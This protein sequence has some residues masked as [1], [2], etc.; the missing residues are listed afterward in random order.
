MRQFST[1][2][3]LL[4]ILTV[5][6]LVSGYLHHRVRQPIT[7]TVNAWVDPPLYPEVEP[8][9]RH[10]EDLL[11]EAEALFA[12]DKP[13]QA[14][15][16]YQ[17]A[18]R[19]LEEQPSEMLEARAL[20]GLGDVSGL[21][22]DL[23]RGL[24]LHQ[25]ARTLFRRLGLTAA[26]AQSLQNLGLAYTSL[27]EVDLAKDHFELA[28]D[29]YRA[30]WRRAIVLM[31]LATQHDLEGDH[32]LAVQQLRQAFVLLS[33]S[34][35]ATVEERSLIKS[36]LL[37]RLAGASMRQGSLDVAELAF[38]SSLAILDTWGYPRDRAVARSNFGVLRMAQG[39]PDLARD[40]ILAGLD[41][42][43]ESS[44]DRERALLHFRL[45]QAY[46]K[47]EDFEAAQE[48]LVGSL[49]YIESALQ[50]T[51]TSVLR[52][53]FTA[54]HHVIREELIALLLERQRLEKDPQ[55]G[56]MALLTAERGRSTDLL[57]RLRTDNRSA[58]SD[59]QGK[60]SSPLRS[61]ERQIRN[62]EHQRLQAIA[63]GQG[64]DAIADAEAQQR[65]LIFKRQAMTEAEHSSHDRNPEESAEPFDLAQV[66]RLLDPDTLLLYYS[67]G[68]QSSALWQIDSAG[69]QTHELPHQATLDPWVHTV[70]D[71]L[72]ISDQELA[73][74]LL[75]E[76]RQAVETLSATL[77]D[78]VAEALQGQRLVILTDGPLQ[79]LPFAVLEHPIHGRRL[80]ADHDIVYV[81]S[82]SA[83]EALR[84][85]ELQ[86]PTRSALGVTV[87]ADPRYASSSV[88]AHPSHS[89]TPPPLTHSAS[90][91]E[92]IGDLLPPTAGGH[93]FLG[94]E[95]RRGLLI[96]NIL[97]PSDILHFSVHGELDTARP[98]LSHLIFALW[99]DE[100]KPLDGRLYVHEIDGIDLSCDLLVLSACNTARGKILRGEGLVGMP[101]AAL[102]A[103]AQR[104][105]VS[106]WFV[107]DEATAEL[108]KHFYSALLAEGLA[109]PAALAQ[110]KRRLMTQ[111][112]P[113]WQ[114]PYYWAGFVL[115]GDWRW[116]HS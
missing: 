46:R 42:L 61:I 79:L 38:R 55:F 90:E 23:Y 95:A 103:G 91:A 37:D 87:V 106:L 60:P 21:F 44:F 15:P 29:R 110:A 71:W 116:P 83:L 109:P 48:L 16:V 113:E 53:A 62:L 3:R 1:L 14:F 114:R 40:E 111:G 32:G 96:D 41:M 47:L 27:G 86:R 81:P 75:R 8:E 43:P 58:H 69:I 99:D 78:P 59:G 22:G 45:A 85:R 28:F 65:Q 50:A 26:E 98:E 54:R 12:N 56:A 20:E 73:P 107:D 34:D 66:H 24:S 94:S 19:A 63:N 36:V 84:D 57:Y 6:L 82:L 104:A 80:V 100:E 18:L 105:L 13:E 7:S 93:F 102:G 51:S 77:L 39:Q 11:I 89:T 64:V 112:N 33:P 74:D 67:V 5:T 31:E 9:L 35:P 92:A 108:M 30:P 10:I 97:P 49:D 115:Y 2:G 25:R 88:T 101:F 17:A 76:A 70:F 68:S 72:A 52:S 4:T